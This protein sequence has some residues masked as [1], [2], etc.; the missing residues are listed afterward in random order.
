MIFGAGMSSL[1]YI[2]NKH[3]K[4]IRIRYILILA[5]APTDGLDDT[6]WTA[7]YILFYWATKEIL[8]EFVL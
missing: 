7:E 6:I 5:K 8:F 3:I 1:A 4:N 2:D